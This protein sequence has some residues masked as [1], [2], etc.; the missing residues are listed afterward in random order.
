[1]S[2]QTLT[3][4]VTATNGS[5]ITLPVE[6]LTITTDESW[7]PSIQAE[8]TVPGTAAL[9]IDPTATVPWVCNVNATMSDLGLRILGT[10]LHIRKVTRDRTSGQVILSASSEEAAVMTRAYLSSSTQLGPSSWA[11]VREGIQD[12]LQQAGVAAFNIDL[13]AMPLALSPALA[14]GV[15]IQPGDPW[16]PVILDLPRRVGYR[17]YVDNQAKWRV[18]PL[19]APTTPLAGDPIATYAKN[20]VDWSEGVS[21]DVEG[22]GEWGDATAC[23]YTWTDSA[24]AAHRII[25]TAS[26]TG[27]PSQPSKVVRVDTQGVVVTQAQANA[28]ATQLLTR[29]YARHRTYRI[30]LAGVQP[31]QP[32]F[33]YSVVTP[34]G[35]TRPL[36]LAACTITLPAG[37]TTLTM[38]DV[39]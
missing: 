3:L 21:R 8:I 9:G 31:Y 2:E 22:P 39:S 32:G 4:E 23:V 26:A 7:T 33:T 19:T 37:T 1:M 12:L 15:V 16:W 5:P 20:V 27:L 35:T 28:A 13:S 25:G 34:E 30:T 38:R 29:V 18:A 10:Q 6:A 36:Y 11:G 14:S 17:L 24:G